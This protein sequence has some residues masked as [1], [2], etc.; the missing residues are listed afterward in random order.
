M[1]LYTTIALIAAIVSAQ[2]PNAEEA[3]KGKKPC[4]RRP[5]PSFDCGDGCG[6]CFKNYISKMDFYHT[7]PVLSG[8]GK[9]WSYFAVGNYTANDG[10]FQ[11]D[12]HGGVIDSSRYTLWQ[13]PAENLF[14]DHNKFFIYTDG[15]AD[16]PKN[17][18]LV[19]EFEGSGETYRTDESKFL[20]E[21]IQPFDIRAA[22]VAYST[23]DRETGFAFDW[24]LTNDRVYVIYARYPQYWDNDV[25]ADYAVFYFAIPVKMR[26]NCDWHNMKTVLHGA[27]K[28]VSYRLDGREVFRVT[29]PGYLLDRQYMLLDMGGQEGPDFPESVAWGLGTFTLVNYYPACK[30]SDT[31]CDCKFPTVRQALTRTGDAAAPEQYNPLLGPINPAIF[32]QNNEDPLLAQESDFIWGQGAKLLIKKL[33]VYQDYCAAR[34][35]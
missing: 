21:I 24:V 30:R 4:C 8:A 11:F 5:E 9:N 31:C 20:P 17:A 33:V 15:T 22:N 2:L 7:K 19:V 10:L 25:T 32:W 13:P 34:Q 6:G 1:K 28:Q 27:T 26:K 23:F 3:E 14:L 35:C 18:D 12:C 29:K 16:V